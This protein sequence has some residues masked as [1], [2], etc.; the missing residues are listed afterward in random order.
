MLP[1]CL[2]GWLYPKRSSKLIQLVEKLQWKPRYSNHSTTMP[3][4]A[5]LK[6]NKIKKHLKLPRFLF[7]STISSLRFFSLTI[8]LKRLVYVCCLYC[9]PYI[10]VVVQLSYPYWSTEINIFKCWLTSKCRDVFTGLI[11][12]NLCEQLISPVHSFNSNVLVSLFTHITKSHSL[13]VKKTPK[14]REEKMNRFE[15][16][17][18]K[19][20]LYSK[21]IMYKIKSWKNHQEYL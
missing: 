3:L 9:L 13:G 2:V 12:L 4:Q 8:F 20:L 14:D 21:D 19:K 18:I 15:N 16:M 11:L 6:N 17:K 1:S 10:L 7:K 5:H